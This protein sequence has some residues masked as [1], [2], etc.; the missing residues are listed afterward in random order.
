MVRKSVALALAVLVTTSVLAT[1][2]QAADLRFFAY[3]PDSDSARF[4][5]QDLIVVIKPGLLSSRVLKLYRRRGADL[6]LKGSDGSIQGAGLSGALPGDAADGLRVYEVDPRNG[7]G[8]AKGACKGSDRAWIALKAPKAYENLRI[9]VVRYDVGTKQSAL[10]ETL[11][12]HWRGEWTL[13]D[14][15]AHFFNESGPASSSH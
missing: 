12:Y 5:T 11:D 9:Y 10:C 2:V 6:D 4:R 7:E 14:K 13:P 3:D 15:G 8:F 1:A